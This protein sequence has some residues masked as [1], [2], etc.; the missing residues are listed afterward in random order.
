MDRELLKKVIIGLLFIGL[1]VFVYHYSSAFIPILLAFFTALILEPLIQFILKKTK[2]QRRLPAVA[3]AFVIYVFL[4]SGVMYLTV[5]KLFQQVVR[6]LYQLP[7]YISD[8]LSLNLFLIDEINILISDIPQKHLIIQE[9]E[10]QGVI[11]A[12]KASTFAQNLIPV[13]ASWVQ[14]IP[15]LLVIFIVYLITVF[16]FSL[17]LPTLIRKFY[18]LFREETAEKISYVFKRLGNV[19]VGFFK[20]QLLVSIIIFIAAYIGLLLIVPERALLMALIIWIIDVIPFIGSILV[21]GPWII[22]TLVVG[23]SS[24]AAKLVVLQIVLLVLR[25]TLEPKILG[26]HIGLPALPMLLSMYFGIYFLG[27]VGLVLG[28][29]IFI[30]VKS[31]YE[32]KIFT[33]DYKP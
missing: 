12:T 18:G 5:T 10:K 2:W 24:L 13:I 33:I 4:L 6:L 14:A 25:R 23:N 16:L 8:I 17:D 29:L 26:E 31:A 32:A 27:V 28:P 15:A 19:V 22:Y 11:L 20:A 21:L 1:L 9:I 30:A 3:I 7:H